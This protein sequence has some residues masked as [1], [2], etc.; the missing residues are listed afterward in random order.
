MVV[1]QVTYI[2][3]L[4]SMPASANTLRNDSPLPTPCT[5]TVNGMSNVD[6]MGWVAKPVHIG[7]LLP[8]SILNLASFIIVWI[9]IAKDAEKRSCHEFDLTDPR[10]LVSA[11]SCLDESDHSGWADGVSYR[12]REVRECQI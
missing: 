6:V 9:S 12:P 11:E 1:V 10:S 5:R 3:L 8:M 2:R 4:Y 7:F